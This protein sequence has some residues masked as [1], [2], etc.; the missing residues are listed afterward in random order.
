MTE[1]RGRARRVGAQALFLIVVVVVLVVAGLATLLGRG[2][3]PA[4]QVQPVASASVEPSVQQRPECAPEV[5]ES[6]AGAASTFGFV[7]RSACDQVVRALVFKVTGLDAAG[8]AVAEAPIAGGVLFPGETLA[9]AGDFGDAAVAAI[10]VEVTGFG[11]FP[12]ADFS[13]WTH[14][15]VASVTRAA[16]GAGGTS[17]WTGT[18]RTK[19]AGVPACVDRFVLIIRDKSRKIVYAAARTTLGASTVTPSFEVPPVPADVAKS[20]IYAPQA[21][22]TVEAPAPGVSCDGT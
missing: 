2:G 1:E 14:A 21:P 20:A 3:E 12:A 11:A 18:L 9:A 4:A 10:G 17:A 8:A 7:Y 13:G 19:P 15:S 6:G 16:P 22:R 5:V